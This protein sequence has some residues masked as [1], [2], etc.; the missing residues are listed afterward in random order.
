MR[1]K[2]LP[3]MGCL[4]ALGAFAG[5]M[6]ISGT[7]AADTC[8]TF[9]KPIVIVGS[10]AVSNFVAK[11]GGILKT[12]LDEN[13][14]PDPIDVL[15]QK[16]GSCVGAG[17]MLDPSSAGTVT[18]DVFIY[19]AN[20]SASSCTLAQEAAVDIGVSDV[21]GE[22]C[23]YEIPDGVKDFH[24]PIQS[25]AFAASTLS[26][27]TVMSF[28]AAYLALGV[29]DT[30]PDFLYNDA[31]K[32]WFRDKFSGTQQ[33]IAHAIGVPGDKF[34]PA[35]HSTNGAGIISA[36][37]ASASDTDV[38]TASFGILSADALRPLTDVVPLAYQHKGQTCGYYPS[39][40]LTKHD[41][42]NTRDG[43]YFIHGPVHMFTKVKSNGTPESD[44]VKSFVDYL[45]G[46]VE[47]VDLLKAEADLSIVPECAMRVA[48]DSEA[49]PLYSFVSPHGMC[50]CA[51]LHYAE[52][53]QVP[54]EC[55]TCDA[56]NDQDD[57]TNSDCEDSSRAHCHYG[58]CEVI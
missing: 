42:Q 6:A 32:L 41:M 1:T 30:D 24:G 49:G 15:Y 11:I 38:A 22:T 55:T 23:D 47:F 57:G 48:R 34:N 43:H 46:T 17:L 51:F 21:F 31:T 33:M 4:A 2:S 16:P 52:P 45:S 50:E 18:G 5:S 14:D 28:E 25:M 53:S 35:G 39:S 10:S 54:S 9:A 29:G 40:E 20:G 58:F 3:F 12:H 37:Q 7:A 27:Q 56:A 13:G 44:A 8:P 36:L 19:D 26:S